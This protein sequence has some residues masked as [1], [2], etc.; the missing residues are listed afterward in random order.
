MVAVSRG[1][2]ASAVD[3]L[4]QVVVFVEETKSPQAMQ[5]LFEVAAG[6]AASRG[7]WERAAQLFGAAER[8]VEA[9]DY[10]RDPADEAYLSSWIAKTR[11]AL[12]DPRFAAAAVAGR[13]AP[14]ATEAAAIGQWLAPPA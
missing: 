8:H 2:D 11:A 10:R 6:L 4:R 12:G 9:T 7:E 1:D 3:P 14:Y 5:S 13:S